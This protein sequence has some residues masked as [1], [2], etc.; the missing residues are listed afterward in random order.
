MAADRRRRARER[1][2][3]GAE[4]FEPPRLSGSS[5]FT[6]RRIQP[7]CHTPVLLHPSSLIPGFIASCGTRTRSNTVTGCRAQTLTPTRPASNLLQPGA[8]RGIEPSPRHSQCRVLPLHHDR[9]INFVRSGRGGTRT[10]TART[11]RPRLANA[12]DETD[13]R[14]SSV[15]SAPARTR[16][17]TSSFASSRGHPF[18]HG[19][20]KQG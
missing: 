12:C 11:E 6:A 10:L 5:G 8:D 19:D 16:T 18:H 3:V 4:G 15:P 1:V 7:L 14:L 13:I 20:E 17:W 2:S 9:H